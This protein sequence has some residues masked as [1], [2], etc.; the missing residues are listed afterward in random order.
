[1]AAFKLDAGFSSRPEV[2]KVEQR[3]ALAGMARMVKI[4]ELLTGSPDPASGVI[5]MPVSDWEEVMQ[6]G[7]V[8]LMPFLSYL[9]QADWLTVDPDVEVGAPLRVTVSNP[10]QYLVSDAALP[11]YPQLF[12]QPAEW[13]DWFVTEL[14][15][16]GYAVD[17]PETQQLFRRWCATN[18]TLTEIQAA[19][20]LAITARQAPTPAALHEYIKAVRKLKLEDARR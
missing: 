9:Q 12:S 16:P 17:T 14:T 8:L 20:E 18:V 11:T 5:E 15:S 19:I 4:L 3:F 10:Q 1:V 6:Q 2:K 7:S 13:R